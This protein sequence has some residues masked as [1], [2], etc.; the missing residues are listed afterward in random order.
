MEIEVN[1]KFL[2]E[3]AALPI[4]PRQ[5]IEKIY[6]DTSLKTDYQLL[7]IFCLPLCTF[8]VQQFIL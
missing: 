4:K 8:V 1:K 7:I 5:K 2:K 6:T 3:L